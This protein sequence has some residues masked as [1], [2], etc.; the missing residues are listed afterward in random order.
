M[1]LKVLV[2]Y[3]FSGNCSLANS[4]DFNHNEAKRSVKLKALSAL[5]AKKKKEKFTEIDFI[6]L[7]G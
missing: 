7:F 4:D 5:Q 6:G 3:F 1:M 2:H